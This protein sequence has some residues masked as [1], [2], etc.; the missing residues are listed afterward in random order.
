MNE[1]EPFSIL[2]IIFIISL[3]ICYH[4]YYFVEKKV[5]KSNVENYVEKIELD[6]N[7]TN[8]VEKVN[9]EEVSENYIGVLSIPKININ[10]SFYPINSLNNDV[11]KNI[12]ILKNSDMPDVDYGVMMIAA[13]SGSSYISFFKDLNKLS[14]DDEVYIYYNNIKYTY[15]V[16]KIYEQERD[17]TISF[18]KNIHETILVLTTCGSEGKQLIVIAKRKVDLINE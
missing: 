12:Q 9:N 7:T 18:D 5:N 11:N 1:K 4:L 8:V 16:Q 2:V 3:F 15:Y 6:N 17:G 10:R 13:H 14:L